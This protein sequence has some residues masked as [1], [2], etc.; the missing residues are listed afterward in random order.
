MLEYNKRKYRV[1]P[2]GTIKSAGRD[3][4]VALNI[5]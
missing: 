5:S 1:L 2:A 3:V 4:E